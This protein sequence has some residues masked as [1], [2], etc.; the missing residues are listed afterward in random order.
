[1][2]GWHGLFEPTLQQLPTPKGQN[3]ATLFVHGTLKVLL[4]A[5]KGSD[6]QNSA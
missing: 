4:Y 3:T 1:M 2:K 6:H 5:P